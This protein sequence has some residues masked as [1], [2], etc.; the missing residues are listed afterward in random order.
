MDSVDFLLLMTLAAADVLLLVY[1][2]R[3]R[4]RQ[5]RLA[6]MQHSLVLAIRQVNHAEDA[7]R[8]AAD[9]GSL[10]EYRRRANSRTDTRSASL[11]PERGQTRS[12]SAAH[13]RSRDKI[14]RL[15]SIRSA[16][17]SSPAKKEKCGI[18]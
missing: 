16:G 9:T 8:K 15:F 12:E 1:L 17:P 14:E 11:R 3:R 4:R 7:R 5:M 10:A 6:R 2:R 18:G 13:Y